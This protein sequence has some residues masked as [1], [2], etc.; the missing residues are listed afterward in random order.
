MIQSNI[1]C[2]ISQCWR[3]KNYRHEKSIGIELK[4]LASNFGKRLLVINVV[5][6]VAVT[7][8]HKSSS[9]IKYKMYDWNSHRMSYIFWVNLFSIPSDLDSFCHTYPST[10]PP[11]VM[12]QLYMLIG[13]ELIR[14]LE[15]MQLPKV[16][17]E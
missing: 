17:L 8:A 4:I 3:L 15:T 13:C 14:N 7:V 2:S 6:D 11:I 9:N 10:I 1:S 16:C 5:V 12:L